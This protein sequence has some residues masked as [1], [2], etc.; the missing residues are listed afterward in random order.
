MPQDH[1]TIERLKK[2][3]HKVAQ[4]VMIDRIYLPLFERLEREIAEREKAIDLFERA[5]AVANG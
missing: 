3:H 2:A 5:K 4:L 1:V